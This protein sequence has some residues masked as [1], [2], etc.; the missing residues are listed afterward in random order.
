[1]WIKRKIKDDVKKRMVMQFLW[2]YF[3]KINLFFSLPTIRKG[4]CMPL[5]LRE[6]DFALTSNWPGR[7]VNLNCSFLSFA[8]RMGK[9]STRTYRQW[10]RQLEPNSLYRMLEQ[11]LLQT[12][13]MFN[14]SLEMER[15]TCHQTRGVWRHSKESKPKSLSK[16]LNKIKSKVVY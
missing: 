6:K 2:K 11:C 13:M 12:K 8:I 5:P 16:T 1:M 7:I 15:Q 14:P 3:P 4:V 9:S 10:W